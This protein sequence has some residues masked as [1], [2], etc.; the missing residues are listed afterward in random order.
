MSTDPARHAAISIPEGQGFRECPGVDTA[1]GQVITRN[2]YST[3]LIN[4]NRIGAVRRLFAQLPITPLLGS[5][6]NRG[7]LRSLGAAPYDAT[8]AGVE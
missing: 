4:L 3:G 6:V 8:T 1:N 2:I 7:C 5:S